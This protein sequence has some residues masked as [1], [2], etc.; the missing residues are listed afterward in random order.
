MLSIL[1]NSITLHATRDALRTKVRTP[2]FCHRE[3]N[4]AI[5]YLIHPQK[6]VSR[7]MKKKR[8]LSILYNSI[9][10]HATRDALRT[11]VHTP[12]FGHREHSMAISHLIRSQQMPSPFRL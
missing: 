10:L 11:K 4:M 12:N 5:G 7:R 9:T 1:Y 6:S 3:R 8:V 2:I